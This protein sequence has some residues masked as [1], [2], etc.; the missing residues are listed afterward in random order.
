MNQQ[1]SSIQRNFFFGRI[2]KKLFSGCC[3]TFNVEEYQWIFWAVIG[4]YCSLDS[5]KLYVWPYINAI[6]Y[7]FSKKFI[8]LKQIYIWFEDTFFDI[9][10]FDAK[11]KKQS[12]SLC[13]PKK[14]F[15]KHIGMHEFVLFQDIFFNQRNFFLGLEDQILSVFYH[16]FLTGKNT[17]KIWKKFLWKQESFDSAG[18]RAH[19]TFQFDRQSKTFEKVSKTKNSNIENRFLEP[20]NVVFPLR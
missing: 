17:M 3:K 11:K 13:K 6:I 14:L 5:N 12:R 19:R 2:S 1:N 18:Y 10:Y 8:W 20:P 16:F 15:F 9:H 4:R 7:L